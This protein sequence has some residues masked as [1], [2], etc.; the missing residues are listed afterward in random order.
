MMRIV[1]S[2]FGSF[3]DIH[4]Y[5][6]IAVELKARGHTPVIATSQV[7]REKLEALRI[8]FHPVR[9][10]MPSPDDPDE[11][12]RVVEEVMDARRVASSGRATLAGLRA[13]ALLN[14]VGPAATR[15]ARAHHRHR[16]S[17]I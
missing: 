4:P 16:L 1:I 2:T 5:V 7:Y 3:G 14:A 6:A 8:D 12:G 9:P 15:L 17:F 13:G 11:V 10:P